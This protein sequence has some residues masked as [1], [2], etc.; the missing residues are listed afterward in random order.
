MEI[1]QI[2]FENMEGLDNIF[3]VSNLKKEFQSAVNEQWKTKPP[4]KRYQKKLIADLVVLSQEKERAVDL[5]NFE[6]LRDTDRLYSIRH[7]KSKK[8]I[9]VIYTVDEGAIILL[10]AFL[11]KNDGDYKR[12]IN[13]AERRLKLLESD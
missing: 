2:Y 10:V 11:E 6:K 13:V 5:A 7:P 9:R 8:N 3:A 4:W 12:A 1:D